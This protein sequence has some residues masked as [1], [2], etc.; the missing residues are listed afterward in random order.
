[1]TPEERSRFYCGFSN[2]VLW[3]LFHDLQSQC[4]FDPAYWDTHLTVNRRFAEKAATK[5]N[6]GT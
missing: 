3:P 4:N 1:M 6:P 2:E 5:R